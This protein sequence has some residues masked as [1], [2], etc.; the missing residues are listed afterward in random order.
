[1]SR[2]AW[3]GTAHAAIRPTCARNQD[4]DTDVCEEFS[5][6]RGIARQLILSRAQR[7]HGNTRCCSDEGLSG[8]RMITEC[9]GLFVFASMRY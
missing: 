3:R 4:T 1:M 6:G 2:G 8:E 7:Y 5:S 9:V